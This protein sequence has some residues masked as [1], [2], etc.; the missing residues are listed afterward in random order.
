MIRSALVSG[1]PE[2]QL[3]RF[4]QDILL[5]YE[6]ANGGVEGLSRRDLYPDEYAV[7]FMADED[8]GPLSF[9]V[10]AS[11]EDIV[12]QAGT[13]L[14]G[15]SPEEMAQDADE[16]RTIFLTNFAG[17]VE[18]GIADLQVGAHRG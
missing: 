16:I 10:A 11:F 9:F 7:L 12:L 3:Q 15:K 4:G 6:H 5:V 13:A 2:A 18:S 1:N 8:A 17:E 14:D